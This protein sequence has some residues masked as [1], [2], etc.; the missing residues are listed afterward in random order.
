MQNTFKT[1]LF[2]IFGSLRSSLRFATLC[3]A[4]LRFATPEHPGTVLGR[5]G[6]IW[7]LSGPSEDTR[8]HLGTSGAIQAN[9]GRLEPS[10]AIRGYLKP[11]GATW[12]HLKASG[13]IQ[14]IWYL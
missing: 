8:G 6:A 10:G 11:F 13:S 5:L 7:R 4:L 2:I 1:E 14:A 12:D 9:C 3:Y